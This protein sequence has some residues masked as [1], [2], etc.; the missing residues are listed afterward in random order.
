MWLVNSSDT[1]T[2]KQ[3]LL[4]NST[5]GI[6]YVLAGD[7]V[8]LA[9]FGSPS[10][11]PRVPDLVIGAKV[12]TLWNVEAKTAAHFFTTFYRS[13]KE[14]GRKKDAFYEAQS[15]TRREYPKYWDWGAFQLIGS[16]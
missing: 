9:G 1:Q 6:S 3:N 14:K 12:G 7:E 16:W 10:L 15:L 2:A 13:L 5:L 4:A 8:A 11:D